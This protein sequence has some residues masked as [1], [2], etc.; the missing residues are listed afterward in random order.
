MLWFVEKDYTVSVVGR[1]K[2]RAVLEEKGPVLKE[3][4]WR[5]WEETAEQQWKKK[6]ERRRVK[7][8]ADGLAEESSRG[9]VE[10]NP[11]AVRTYYHKWNN[12][13][14]GALPRLLSPLS[15]CRSELEELPSLQN[16]NHSTD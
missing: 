16:V 4:Q 2:I 6:K 5:T 7:P 3:Q 13:E 12:S 11:T 9:T 15:P 14:L 10:V 1:D 8:E